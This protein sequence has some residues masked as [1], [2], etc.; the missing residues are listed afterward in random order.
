MKTMCPFGGLMAESTEPKEQQFKYN[1]KEFEPMSGINLYDYGARFY[2]PVLGRFTPQDPLAEKYGPTSP[3]V[4]CVNDPI[5]HIDPNGKEKLNVLPSNQEAL[6]YNVNAFKDDP[7]VINIWGHGDGYSI[8][9]RNSNN[10]ITNSA[11]LNT[12]L[13]KES[14]LWKEHI[15]GKPMTIVLHSCKNASFAKALSSSKEFKNVTIIG[16]TENIKVTSDASTYSIEEVKDNGK[17][18]SYK[19]GKLL[20]SHPSDWQPGSLEPNANEKF[21]EFSKKLQDKLFK[22]PKFNKR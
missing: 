21:K 5:K 12:F 2:D 6:N 18:Q 14:K 17:W 7:S 19:N 22:I 15:S 8:G 11:Q 4:Y 20:E 1:G 13:L 10:S 16:A 3:Y 9:V